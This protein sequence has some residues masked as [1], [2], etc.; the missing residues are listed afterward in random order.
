MQRLAARIS[1]RLPSAYDRACYKATRANTIP[2]LYW[3]NLHDVARE[4]E[5][6][7]T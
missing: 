3:L 7:V 2:G 6:E 4:P 5:R 1:G